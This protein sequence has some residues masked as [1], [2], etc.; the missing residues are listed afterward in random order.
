M[1]NI[2][3]L[4]VELTR[5]NMT[6]DQLADSADIDR[7]TLYRRLKN[8]QDFT[9][10]EIARICKALDLSQTRATEIFFDTEVA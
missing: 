6:K 8:P 9:V 5:H 1:V 2:T 7:S 3:E 10:G 4:T